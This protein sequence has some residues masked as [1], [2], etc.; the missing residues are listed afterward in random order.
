M[1]RSDVWILEH[2]LIDS[3]DTATIASSTSRSIAS[4]VSLPLTST[5]ASEAYATP[6]PSNTPSQSSS[7]TPVGAIAGGVVGGI[8]GLAL[9][10]L[11]VWFLMRRKR[12]N[13]AELHGNPY[14]LREQNDS[15]GVTKYRAEAEGRAVHEIGGYGMRTPD[16]EL[17]THQRPVELD[18]QNENGR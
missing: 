13:V 7:S 4:T 16:A 2:L 5:S 1:F 10:G 11:L 15:G 3:E 6:T 12:N 18:A 17:P 9:L 8:V 14:I